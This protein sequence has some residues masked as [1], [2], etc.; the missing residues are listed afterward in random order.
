[1]PDNKKLTVVLGASA[2]PSRYA[3]LA[4]ERLTNHGQPFKLVSIKKGEVFGQQFLDLK[5]EPQIEDVH[6]ITLYIGT[7]RLT[8]WMD[9]ILRLKPKRIIFNPGT[10]HMELA[11]LSEAQGVENVFGCTL[12]MLS[13]GQY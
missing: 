11:K 12:V 2:N 5:S 8:E 4:A 3:Y 6:T 10:E 7:I 9:Y 1:M 13:T